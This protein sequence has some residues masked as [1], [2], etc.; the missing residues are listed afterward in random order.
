MSQTVKQRLLAIS[1]L[2]CALLGKAACKS[3]A[4][5]VLLQH[6]SVLLASTALPERP[7]Q[8]TVLPGREVVLIYFSLKS[9][10]CAKLQA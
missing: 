8:D 6:P 4:C 5:A 1:P 3:Q 7:L 9:S 10:Q 2:G